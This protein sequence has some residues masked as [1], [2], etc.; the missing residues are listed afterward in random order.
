MVK[1]SYISLSWIFSCE[2]LLVFEELILCPLIF[3]GV[4]FC[5]KKAEQKILKFCIWGF[6]KN[7][8]ILDLISRLFFPEN[9]KSMQSFFKFSWS[10]LLLNSSIISSSLDRFSSSPISFLRYISELVR[11]PK[12]FCKS[13]ILSFLEISELINSSRFPSLVW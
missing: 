7:F 4:C 3:R 6:C 10:I 8:S 11:S 13:S 2:E 9:S 1:S 5:V 12:I